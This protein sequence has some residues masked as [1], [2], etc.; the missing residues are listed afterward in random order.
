MLYFENNKTKKFDLLAFSSPLS[1][2]QEQRETKTPLP[3]FNFFLEHHKSLIL[4][5]LSYTGFEFFITMCP[6]V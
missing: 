5:L 2:L 6:V 3:S 4:I 1:T